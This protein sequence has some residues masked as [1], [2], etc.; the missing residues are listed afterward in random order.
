MP[1][2]EPVAV[3]IEIL[4]A[5]THFEAGSRLV[6]DVLGHEPL[7]YAVF[8]HGPLVNR[9]FHR[10]YTGGQYDSYLAGLAIPPSTSARPAVRS[11][12]PLMVALRRT[13]L[14]LRHQ[15]A[16]STPASRR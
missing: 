10:I 13:R 16:H 1:R 9:G 6:L 7:T 8:E 14:E 5:S 2:G 4:P 11:G 15:L 12:V 3:D